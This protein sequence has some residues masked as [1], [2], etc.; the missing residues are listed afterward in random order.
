MAISKDLMGD[1]VIKSQCHVEQH[2]IVRSIGVSIS[3]STDRAASEFMRKGKARELS[4]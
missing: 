4:E 1:V 2:G 3:L